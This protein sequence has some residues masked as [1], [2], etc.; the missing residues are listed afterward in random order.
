MGPGRILGAMVGMYLVA[1]SLFSF[2][3][4]GFSAVG[5]REGRRFL[6]VSAWPAAGAMLAIGAFALAMG[7]F[8]IGSSDPRYL[9]L[10]LLWTL[11]IGAFGVGLLMLAPEYGRLAMWAG[12][13]E[14]ISAAMAIPSEFGVPIL[15]FVPGYILK[16]KL[17]R[18]AA[19]KEASRPA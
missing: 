19:E 6:Q 14:L 3:L 13:L 12:W 9:V 7:K 18:K 8:G 4:S 17:L 5:K 1:L 11:C 10:A 16:R 15:L 2:F